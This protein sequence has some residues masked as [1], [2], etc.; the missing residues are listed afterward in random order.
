MKKFITIIIFFLISNIVY[1]DINKNYPKFDIKEQKTNLLEIRKTKVTRD[2]LFVDFGV[3]PVVGCVVYMNVMVII[4][5][6][7]T[8]TLN[9][10]I[11]CSW[12]FPYDPPF[13]LPDWIAPPGIISPP[14]PTLPPGIHYLDFVISFDPIS[15]GYVECE[16]NIYGDNSNLVTLIL[17]GTGYSLGAII[18]SYTNDLD[19]GI[20]SVGDSDTMSVELYNSGD[21]DL[22][23]NEIQDAPDSYFNFIS[24][25]DSIIPPESSADLFIE[26]FPQ[27]EGIFNDSLLIISNAYNEDSLFINLEGEAITENIIDGYAYLDNQTQHDSIEVYF[28]M[29]AP[30]DSTYTAYTDESGYYGL[31][32]ASGIYDVTYSKNGYYPIMIEDEILYSNTTLDDIT[33]YTYIFIPYYYET[34]QEGIDSCFYGDTVLVDTGTYVENINFEGKNITVA[35]LYLT[36]QDTSYISQTIIDGDNSGSVVTFENGEDSNAVLTGFTI[37]NGNADY[38]GGIYCSNS[39]PSLVNVTISDNS[40]NGSDSYGGGI[41]LDSSYT[42]L[43]NVTI[44]DNSANYGGGIYLTYS[45]ACLENVTITGNYASYGGGGIYLDYSNPS[46]EYILIIENSSTGYNVSGGGVYCSHSNPNIKNATISCNS[47]DGE[48]DGQGAGIYLDNSSP[49]LNNVDIISNTIEGWGHGGGIYC[50][51]YSSPSLQNVTISGNSANWEGGGIYC[52]DSSPSLKNCIVSD[53]TGNYGIYADSGNPTI[54]YSDFYNNEDGN[55]YGCNQYIGFNVTTN[56]NGDSCD[57]WYNI[58]EDPLFV[59]PANGDY[60]LTSNSPCIDAGNPSTPPDPDG[61]VA[62]MGAYYFDQGY[63]HDLFFSE[64]IEGTSQNKALEVY[65]GSGV[66]V[67]LTNYRIAQSV[68]GNGWQYWH[69]FPAG[70]TLSSGDVWVMTTDEANVQLQDVA[71]EILSYPSVVHHNGNDARGL[72]KTTDGGTTWT[73]I[74][75]IGIPDNDPGDGWDVAGVTAATLNHT[76]VRKTAIQGGNTNWTSSAG[77]ST[78]DSEW[79][80]YPVDTFEYLGS[81]GGGVSTGDSQE[82]S[83]YMLT[84][85]PNPISSKINNLSVSFFINKPGKVTIQL[86]NIR[87]QL[88]STLVHEDKNIGEYTINHPINKLSS[89]IYFTKMSIDGI[90]TEVKKM[91]LLR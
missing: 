46:L 78:G 15:P 63:G 44:S 53:N 24:I 88:I 65:N 45:D 25:T 23:I 8:T 64:Y 20:I 40:A 42:C 16:V 39:S 10:D 70:S 37:T 76:L 89:G 90:D 29:Q 67:E 50:Y 34:I 80:V 47:T 6:Q 69:E 74:D 41:Y 5:L 75:V 72:E 13:G 58:Q 7:D 51:Q 22:E 91:I 18:N 27:E 9:G 28:E 56:A 59:D 21:I 54:E 36:S 17:Q 38:G 11:I 68:N 3:V 85:Y 86:F 43:Q 52:D 66:T 83:P 49:S 62:D 81:H 73:L 19:F 14:G 33:I 60:H 4:E 32:I 82:I 48:L 35:S 87:G 12:P 1:G 26:F 55:F 31:G 77:T 30:D 71:D 61:T 57:A 84:N 79:E 2:T